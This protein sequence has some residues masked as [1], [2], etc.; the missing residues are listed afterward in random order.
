M[1]KRIREKWE[2]RDL[3][4]ALATIAVL[5]V[6]LLVF[7]FFIDVRDRVRKEDEEKFAGQTTGEIIEVE[8]IWKM[9]QSRWSG[10]RIYIDGY[11]V[12]Y[13]FNVHGKTF[14]DTDIIPLTTANQKLLSE[15]LERG[16]NSICIVKFDVGDPNNSILVANQVLE[17]ER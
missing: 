17:N 7:F 14:Q 4:S 2:S 15:I 3:K 10:T 12:T 1:N 16:T 5:V 6:A 13:T 8:K 9:S 11:K